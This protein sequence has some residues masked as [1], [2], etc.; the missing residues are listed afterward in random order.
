MI[1]KTILAV[2]AVTATACQ[3]P[4][5]ETWAK[6]QAQGLIPVLMAPRPVPPG[7]P[8]APMVAGSAAGSASPSRENSAPVPPVSSDADAPPPYA[9]AVD[10]RPGFVYS[11]FTGAPRQIDVRSFHADQALRCPYSL[12]SFRVPGAALADVKPDAPSSEARPRSRAE[13]PRRR[14]TAGTGT[15]QEASS[16]PNS[17][18]EAPAPQLDQVP[19]P[20]PEAPA[21]LPEPAAAA[22]P[23]GTR[24]A[25]RPGFVHSPYAQK[26]QL[27][28]V[29]GI[30]PGVEVKCPYT[31]KPFRV[32]AGAEG[33]TDS[34]GSPAPV[35]PPSPEPGPPSTPLPE[36]S[37]VKEITPSG[38]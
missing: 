34:F 16:P 13:E 31:D 27:V 36:S 30:A 24:V 18:A 2:A 7:G 32:P 29:T 35:P 12:K 37:A 4:P 8:S 20:A 22:V 19:I 28:D 33:N 25:G 15:R 38:V 6:I 21:R 9:A 23:Y 5:R 1:A 3:L 11:P 10:G 17:P 14:M 26:H